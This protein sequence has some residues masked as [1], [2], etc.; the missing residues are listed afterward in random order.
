MSTSRSTRTVL[1]GALSAL[2]TLASSS[3]AGEPEPYCG[4]FD[5]A[6]TYDLS[7]QRLSTDLS[8]MRPVQGLLCPR[9]PRECPCLETDE[10]GRI[11]AEL[12][13]ESE[14]LAEVQ[15]PG[16]LTTIATTTTGTEDRLAILRVVDRATVSVLASLLDERVDAT[17]GHVGLRVAPVE[18]ADLTGTVLVL[19]HVET[20]AEQRLLYAAD[21]LPS[22]E[23]T[24]TDETGVALG[25][26]LVPGR[27]RLESDV[28]ATCG[29][30]DAGWP[31]YDESGRIVAV[32]LEVRASAVT[33]IDVLS[34]VGPAR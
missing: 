25:V 26:N 12:P 1:L 6:V 28:L 27:Y 17:R 22:P 21:G 13:A 29:F 34:C 7:L 32:E 20:G 3:C 5:P 10:E 9:L 15:A 8:D 4:G 2:V 23:A 24:S 33:L 19:R 11:R 31:R 18:G 16:F 30:A 14:I